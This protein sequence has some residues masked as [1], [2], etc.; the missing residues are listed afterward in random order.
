MLEI[1]TTAVLSLAVTFPHGTVTIGT[2]TRTIRV[3]VEIAETPAQLNQGLM[4]RR[5][6]AR[7][8][9]MGLG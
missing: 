3:P 8:S 5:T 2:P 7:N 9:G 6:L 1:L 4:G